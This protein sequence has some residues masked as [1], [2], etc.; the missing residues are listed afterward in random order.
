MTK[1]VNKIIRYYVLNFINLINE[2]IYNPYKLSDVKTSDKIYS[3]IDFTK[4]FN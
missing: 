1:K 2:F 4:I 3:R